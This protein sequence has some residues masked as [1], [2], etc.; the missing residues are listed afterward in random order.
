MIRELNDINTLGAIVTNAFYILTIMVFV[1]RIIKKERLSMMIGALLFCL[2]FP[3]IWMLLK[4]SDFD[5][6]SIYYIQIILVLIWMLYTLIADYILK[7]DFRE[8][9]WIVIIYVSFFFAASGGM[10]GIASEAGNIWTVIS[11]ILFILMAIFA[12]VQRTITGK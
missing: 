9:R 3:L 6:P 2:S 8:I 1:F 10:L 5:R 4:A 11:V 12:F 7:W